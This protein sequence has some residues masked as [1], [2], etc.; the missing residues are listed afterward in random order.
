M[1]HIYEADNICYLLL[2]VFG[3]GVIS[4]GE[5]EVLI[6]IWCSFIITVHHPGMG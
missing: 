5:V 3:I 6:L 2:S 4:V 1:A